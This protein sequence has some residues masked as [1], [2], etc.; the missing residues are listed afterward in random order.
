M[1]TSSWINKFGVWYNHILEKFVVFNCAC[2]TSN[3]KKNAMT[4]ATYSRDAGIFLVVLPIPSMYGITIPTWYHKNQPN[5]KCIRIVLGKYTIYM[6]PMGYSFFLVAGF[7]CSKIRMDHWRLRCSAHWI[8]PLIVARGK[9]CL[10]ISW[11]CCLIFLQNILAS[12]PNN[13]TYRLHK[14]LDNT[15]QEHTCN[16][17][18]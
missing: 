15:K 16:T 7:L 3:V 5:D 10:G 6:N 18:I 8:Q 11:C 4:L 14:Q 12:G 9:G 17:W 13:V 1:E 2:V